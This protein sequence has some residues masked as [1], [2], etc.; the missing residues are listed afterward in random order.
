[1]ARLLVR[2]KLR[3]LTNAL[4]SSNRAKAS[5][6]TSTAF[7]VLT[8]L[9]MFALLAS[10]HGQNSAVVL[11][12][13][14]FTVFA[15]GW[16]ILPLLAFG[17]DST[18]DPAT[19]ALYPL[20]TR[21]LAIGLLAASA[22]GAW[23]AANVIGLLGVLIGLA[24]GVLGV[25]VALVAV[26]LQ[27]LFCITAARFV[28]TSMAG[29][30]RSRRGKDL[31]VFLFIPIVAGY[32]FFT[33]VVPRL[34]AAG[35]LTTTSFT[36]SDTW[37]RWLPPGLAAHAIQDASDG[38]PG[39]ALLRLA[40]LAAVIVVLG[41]L[42]IRS[43]SRALVTPDSSTQSSQVRAS[44]GRPGSVGRASTA[45]PFARHGL[46]GAVAARFWIYQRREPISLVYWGMTAVITAAASVGAIA[47]PQ[48]HPGVTFLSAVL[49]AAFIG[50]F[51]ANT[52]GSTG[53][54]FVMEATA[55][56]DR[57]ALRAYL[58]GQ[59][60]VLAVIGIPLLTVLTFGLGAAAGS[61][62]FGFETMP[63]ALAALGAALA[64]SNILTVNGAY[65]MAKRVGTPI[66]TSAPGYGSSRV[67]ATIGTLF[68]IPVLVAPV[69]VAAVLTAGSPLVIRAPVLTACAAAYGLALAW[70]GVG[71]AAATGEGKMPELCQVALA[72]KV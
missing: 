26:L 40:L 64:L 20:R 67:A 41:W 44:G 23:P 36:G 43:L 54:S 63:V 49:G 6:I 5:F 7:A 56:T 17:L 50:L 70:A 13:V 58:S 15:F 16:L 68:G 39:T 47:G 19:M 59:N 65:P 33:Q 51:H 18:L 27:V 14:M 71:I 45:L 32:E 2:L 57:N 42:W 61:A 60:V 10:L 28:T 48:R 53:P 34:A 11:T 4:R 52:V 22:T 1:M 30:L 9:G 24:R 38:H 12:S 8:A 35:K 66:Y 55:L 3:L 69:I 72:S 62:A 21:Q 37:L 31:A 25:F 29:L 46:R